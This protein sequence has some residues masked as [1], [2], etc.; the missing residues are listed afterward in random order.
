MLWIERWNIIRKFKKRQL[1]VS[2]RILPKLI[3]ASCVRY[4]NRAYYGFRGEQ[5]LTKSDNIQ[6]D[7]SGKPYVEL[8]RGIYA[9]FCL[10]V[11]Q[12]RR[13]AEIQPRPGAWVRAAHLMHMRWVQLVQAPWWEL[14]LLF[15]THDE[16]TYHQRGSHLCGGRAMTRVELFSLAASG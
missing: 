1:A 13:S 8:S 16:G 2:S 9:V 4:F 11:L 5:N 6:Y 12:D 7:K 14:L 15:L 3:F 10:K